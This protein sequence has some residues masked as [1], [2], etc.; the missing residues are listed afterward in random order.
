MAKCLLQ[1]RLDGGDHLVTLTAPVA[2]HLVASEVNDKAVG[3]VGEHLHFENVQQ[4]FAT[5]HFPVVRG[6]GGEQ[7]SEQRCRVV[8]SAAHRVLRTVCRGSVGPVSQLRL[9]AAWGC[10]QGHCS[11][12][13]MEG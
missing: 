7:W 3:F 2:V 4:R 9:V 13:E 11:Q 10:V 8:C 1:R 5:L 6:G 12:Q